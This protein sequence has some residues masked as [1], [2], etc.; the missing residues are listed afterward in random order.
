M[1]ALQHENTT[2]RQAAAEGLGWLGYWEHIPILTKCLT[3]DD[4]ALRV[5]AVQALARLDQPI[6]PKW[7][8][9]VILAAKGKKGVDLPRSS[10]DAARLLRLHG[11]GQAAT[12]LVRCL[13][14]DN[15][16][17]NSSYNLYIINEI[18]GCT[19]GPPKFWSEGKYHHDPNTEGTPD[20]IEDNRLALAIW[21]KWLAEQEAVK[22]LA[23]PREV[24][25]SLAEA[26]K[27]RVKHHNAGLAMWRELA[28]LVKPGWT[29]EQMR[30]ILTCAHGGGGMSHG[31]GRVT[32]SYG[33]QEAFMVVAKGEY[34]P[35]ASYEHGDG[36]DKIILTDP[37]TVTEIR[38]EEPAGKELDRLWGELASGDP[39]R[40]DK[41][42]LAMVAMGD[43]A[44]EFLSSRL[45]PDAE[46][47]G[48]AKGLIAELDD[49]RFAVRA[50]AHKALEEIGRPALPVLR[51]ALDDEGLSAERRLRLTQL[52][53]KLTKIQPDEAE[54]RRLGRAVSILGRI[55]TAPAREVLR[56]LAAGPSDD[57]IAAAARQAMAPWA[58]EEF[59]AAS[60]FLCDEAGSRELASKRFAAMAD[61]NPGH[62]NAPV[63]RELAG[64]LG[65]M[66]KEDAGFQEPKAPAALTARQRIDYLVYKLRDVQERAFMVPGKVRV[67]GSFRSASGD[68]AATALRKLGKAAVP[69]LIAMLADRRPTRSRS[70]GLNGDHILRYGD[71]AV[72]IIEAISARQFDKPRGR[73]AYLA[74]ADDATRQ[75]IAR[76]VNEW[77]QRNQHGTEAEWIRQSLLEAGIGNMA[78]RLGSAERLIE[79]EGA[80]SVPFFRQRL[81]AEPANGHLVRLL[82][83]AGGEAVLDDV[84]AK[85]SS[86][87]PA[88]RASAYRILARAGVDGTVEAVLR[89]I[90]AAIKGME[91]ASAGRQL[92]HVSGFVS[93]LAYSGRAEAVLAAARLIEHEDPKVGYEAFRQ[94]MYV[95]PVQKVLAPATVKMLMPYV[96]SALENGK[97]SPDAG[98]WAAWW[99]VKAAKLSIPLPED[100]APA[101]RKAVI[102]AVSG[103][104][105]EHKDE[106]PRAAKGAPGGAASGGARRFG[107]A[108]AQAGQRLARRLHARVMDSVD[109][110]PA[111]DL[112]EHR[113]VVD[114]NGLFRPGVGDVEGDA[115]HVLVRLAEMHVA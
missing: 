59:E 16:K 89:E 86:K 50:K 66:A 8:V 109:A 101:A 39:G 58:R 84:R 81:A 11:K 88:M 68:N 45:L 85:T 63:A 23:L 95:H 43:K 33:V 112:G 83:E 55:K 92:D 67:L 52:V 113:A 41:G 71:V 22:P 74:N 56:R 47:A 7:L 35:G 102:A 110:H 24:T 28:A 96:A 36:E 26:I 21:K 53:A 13:D 65:Q 82:W 99:M 27:I 18:E 75:E 115:V 40:A 54:T 78:N 17:T 94:V 34:V 61:R 104:W 111:G 14:F 29:M 57:A 32:I 69:V 6:E 4:L 108:Q 107:H 106:Y 9:D 20:Q 49:D 77:W 91:G 51:A 87:S 62:R 90:E 79:L 114:V 12:A 5:A 30:L 73:G 64:L 105:A 100:P 3:G 60:A 19:N 76:R 93:A 72:E 10:H 103:W 2:V 70:E 1:A 46:T 42:A 31:N 80:K 44:V 48:R 98:Y 37:P 97:F 15:P 38:P 25:Q